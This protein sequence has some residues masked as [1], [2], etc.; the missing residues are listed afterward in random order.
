MA[1]GRFDGVHLGHQ[2]LLAAGRERAGQDGIPLA[3]YTFPPRTEALLPLAAKRRLLAAHAD[4]VIVRRWEEVR[5]T[6]AEAFVQR[7][8]VGRLGARGVVIGPGHRFGA[9]ARGDAALLGQLAN[10]LNLS[11]HLVEPLR[12]GGTVVRGARIRDLVRAGQVEE[13]AGLLGRPPIVFGCPVAGAGL[14]TALGFPTVNLQ[15]PPRLVPPGPGVYAAWAS[16][17]GGSG[18]GLFYR[19]DRPTFPELGPSAELHLFA[20]P[21][22]RPRG[23]VEVALAA[24]LRGD[25]RFPNQAA[26]TAQLQRDRERAQRALSGRPPPQPVLVRTNQPR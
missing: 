5:A 4:E 11:V 8:L 24:F 22:E 14:A 3:V 10:R 16:W 9:G 12:L 15:L 2:H 1:V 25:Q 17:R 21:P 13:A 7:E 26:L 20:P 18:S 23:T 6:S 19:G